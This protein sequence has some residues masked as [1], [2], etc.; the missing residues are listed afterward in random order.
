M[1]QNVLLPVARG[2]CR[3]SLQVRVLWFLQLTELSAAFTSTNSSLMAA[4]NTQTVGTRWPTV[5]KHTLGPK[6]PKPQTRVHNWPRICC[7]QGGEDPCQRL[8]LS[9]LPQDNCCP[10]H[11]GSCWNSRVIHC[12]DSLIFTPALS[13]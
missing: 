5:G 7:G 8:C 10:A 2:K 13:S 9:N 11:W 4:E 6:R 12:S 3:H 1:R